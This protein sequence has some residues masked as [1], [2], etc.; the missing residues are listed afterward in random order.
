MASS[1]QLGCYP[2]VAAGGEG[3][4]APTCPAR[5]HSRAG[6]CFWTRVIFSR[7]Y[8]PG[9]TSPSHS[10]LLIILNFLG[11]AENPESKETPKLK[12]SPAGSTGHLTLPPL[13]KKRCFWGHQGLW[14]GHWISGSHTTAHM[15]SFRCPKA[16]ASGWPIRAG[17]ERLLLALKAAGQPSLRPLEGEHVIGSIRALRLAEQASCLSIFQGE[18]ISG[19]CSLDHRCL[20]GQRGVCSGAGSGPLEKSAFNGGPNCC[21]FSS[22]GRARRKLSHKVAIPE[23]SSCGSFRRSALL[24]SFLPIISVPT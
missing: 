1:R 24:T 5:L 23:M 10:I 11:M 4:I 13:S 17:C 9:G 6:H 18:C 7:L 20:E 22:S 8:L 2:K 14:W 12:V 19:G 3:R 21:L 15:P 16:W